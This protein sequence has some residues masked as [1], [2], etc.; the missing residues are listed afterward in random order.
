MQ[1][2]PSRTSALLLTVSQLAIH[3]PMSSQFPISTPAC[4]LEIRSQ[5]RHKKCTMFR[6]T[7]VKVG[8]PALQHL[9][10]AIQ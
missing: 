1:E 6:E 2:I 9:R 8:G 3:K 7:E 4:R 5:E 10:L